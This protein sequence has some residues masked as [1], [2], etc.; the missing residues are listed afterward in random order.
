[1]TD[2]IPYVREQILA[3]ITPSIHGD[4]LINALTSDIVISKYLQSGVIYSI[5]QIVDIYYRFKD[6]YTLGDGLTQEQ[7][8]RISE[9]EHIS[10]VISTI[11]NEITRL[12][13][14]EPILFKMKGIV[15]LNCGST[16]TETT[17]PQ[18]T[19]MDEARIEV[20]KCNQCGYVRR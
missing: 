19:A 14:R 5:D 20:T 2:Y 11:D 12:F 16:D 13:R 9:G 18:V 17:T 15:C 6:I 4:A 3:R 7:L 8:I 10:S 1:M